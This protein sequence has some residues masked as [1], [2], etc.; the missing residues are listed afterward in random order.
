[1]GS[2]FVSLDSTEEGAEVASKPM[3]AWNPFFC[4]AGGGFLGVDDD[5]ELPIFFNEY[6]PGRGSGGGFGLAV[7]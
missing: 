1:M 5:S 6:L 3:S 4:S 2:C 7:S